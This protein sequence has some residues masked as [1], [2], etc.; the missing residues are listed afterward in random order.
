MKVCG[1]AGIELAAPGSAIRHAS[2]VRHVT[3]TGL[4]GRLETF[5]HTHTEATSPFVLRGMIAIIFNLRSN[6]KNMCVFRATDLK[7]VGRVD[8][9]IFFWKKCSFLH[10][11]RHFAFQNALKKLQR[12]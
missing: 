11:E 8:T 2:V 6:K 7:I 9:H 3:T 12:T 1:G 10:F 5:E 4:R